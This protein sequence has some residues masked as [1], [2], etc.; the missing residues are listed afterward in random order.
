MSDSHHRNHRQLI[1]FKGELS[2]CY[3]QCIKIINQHARPYFWLGD[4]PEKI[5]S[6]LYKQIL[7]QETSLLI[8]NAHQHFDANLFAASEGTLRGGGL[9]LLISPFHINSQDHFYRYVDQQ[10]D[11]GSFPTLIQ[12]QEEL[13]L[14]TTTL[15]S[16]PALILHEQ[17]Q[18]VE[19]II[20][21]VTGHRR[22][23]LVLTANR[24]RG[25][26]AALG[27][28]AKQLV[29]AGLTH[30]LICAHNKNATLTLF[31]HAG[32]SKQIGFIAPDQ[33]LNEKPNCDLLIVDEAAAIPVPMLEAITLQ[34][35]RLVFATTQHGY[36]GSG[37]GFAL[38]FQQRLQTLAPQARSLHLEQPIRW[39][40]ND[41]VEQFTLNNLCISQSKQTTPHFDC[42]QPIQFNSITALQL[43][44]NHALL[45]ELFSLLVTAHYQTKPS[46]LE[47]LLNDKHL[48]VLTLTQ[49]KQ[50]LAVALVNHEGD[51]DDDLARQIA[52]GKRRLKG[53]LVAQSLTF[54]CANE[55]AATHKYARIQRIATHPAIQQQGLGKELIKQM[56][57][58]A[59]DNDFEHLC[60]SFGANTEL[61]TFWQSQGFSILKIGNS[62]DKSSG[63]HS[64]IVNLPISKRGKALHHLLQA[65]FQSQLVSQIPR[66]LAQLETDL[67]LAVLAEHPKK[68]IHSPLITSYCEGNLPY[69]FAEH[70][71]IEFIIHCDL[72]P[73][74]KPEQRLT[75]QKILQNQ[76][77]ADISANSQYTGKKQAQSA[78]R[79]AIIQL[80][81]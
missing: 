3:Q 52:Q 24:G 39:S 1:R 38:R 27:I 40:K 58:W 25:K 68:L 18:A 45:T 57:D 70:A 69:E 26:S 50:I 64:F 9:L 74:A 4:S 73:L 21:T 56:F 5:T 12:S 7:G 23:P 81:N 2:W 11:Q 36:E 59:N 10:L 49:N 75:I 29:E 47:R 34:Y 20:K 66:H 17:Q 46:D 63:T 14:P 19:A 6:T 71:L 33:L 55:E 8:I 35:S 28:A 43:S 79:N 44:E 65:Q 22:R 48:S 42:S 67:V 72:S 37:R 80:I 15:P 62:K 30:I 78:L 76:S 61:L 16:P 53:H 31:K 32:E 54:H 51:F 41:P 77:W 60:A 13:A